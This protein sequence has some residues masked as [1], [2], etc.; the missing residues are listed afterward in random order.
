MAM[1]LATLAGNDKYVPLSVNV[2][3]F[4]AMAVVSAWIGNAGNWWYHVE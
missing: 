2:Y 3:S 4:R 1:P